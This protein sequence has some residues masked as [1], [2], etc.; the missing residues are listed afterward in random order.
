MDAISK[1][2]KFLNNISHINSG[3]CGVAALAMYRFLKKNG[4]LSKDFKVIFL[5]SKCYKFLYDANTKGGCYGANHIVFKFNGRLY[6]SEG[7]FEIEYTDYVYKH[8]VSIKK[9]LIA[10]NSDSWNSSFNR[11]REIPKIERKLKI[12]LCDI[13]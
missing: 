3:G 8:P 2:I 1:A 12:S 6:D 9:L 10:L 5:Y 11:S 13:L 4:L 7:L